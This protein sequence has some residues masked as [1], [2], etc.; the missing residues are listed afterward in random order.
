MADE[1]AENSDDEKCL[2]KAEVRAAKKKN[3]ASRQ[4]AKKPR[5]VCLWAGSDPRPREPAGSEP[6]QVG[7][8]IGKS[9]DSEG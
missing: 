4:K 5:R 1:L 7:G 2:F 8:C 6:I 3:A 9:A